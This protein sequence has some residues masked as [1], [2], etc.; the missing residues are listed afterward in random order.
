[1]PATSFEPAAPFFAHDYQ[2]VR[3]TGPVS[4]AVDIRAVDALALRVG[5]HYTIDDEFSFCE[6]IVEEVSRMSDGRW[7][8]RCQVFNRLW[9]QGKETGL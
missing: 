4:G 1:M 2:I 8:A 7:N 9:L 5:D 6:M 3:R